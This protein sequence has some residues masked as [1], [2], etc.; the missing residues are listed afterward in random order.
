MSLYKDLFVGLSFY[1]NS[2]LKITYRT[3]SANGK[4]DAFSRRP[5]CASNEEELSS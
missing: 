5:E 4:P 2:I 3:G 1:Q